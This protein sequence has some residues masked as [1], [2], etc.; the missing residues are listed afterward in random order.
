MQMYTLTRTR[1]NVTGLVISV[2]VPLLSA[3]CIEQG[4]DDKAVYA[5]LEQPHQD[6][7]RRW[8]AAYAFTGSFIE[9]LPFKLA[10][11]RVAVVDQYDARIV[12]RFRVEQ[13]H[14]GNVPSEGGVIQ[15]AVHSAAL[16]LGNMDVG[17][18]IK[19]TGRLSHTLNIQN[20]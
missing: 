17:K 20:E 10:S 9:S 11:G 19:V 5:P 15:Y 14:Y 3:C 8:S 4:C 7:D 18:R 2:G 12:M 13:I 6:E 1:I 16:T